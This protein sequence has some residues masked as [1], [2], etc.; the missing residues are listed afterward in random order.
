[1]RETILSVIAWRPRRHSPQSHSNGCFVFHDLK[2]S[3][4]GQTAQIGN[5][6]RMFISIA[7]TAAIDY[8]IHILFLTGTA[9]QKNCVRRKSH[10][11]ESVANVVVGSR[12]KPLNIAAVRYK[13]SIRRGHCQ[14]LSIPAKWTGQVNALRCLSD[15]SRIWISLDF[16]SPFQY[17]MAAKRFN[18]DTAELWDCKGIPRPIRFPYSKYRAFGG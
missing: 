3:L 8:S 13:G 1:M 5:D 9:T 10:T 18:I 6:R 15:F 14:R 16:H 7:S 2:F 11:E 4:T 17:K 12:H